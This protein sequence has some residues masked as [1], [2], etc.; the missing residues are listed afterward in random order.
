ML[1]ATVRFLLIATFT[2]SQTDFE[3]GGLPLIRDV[4]VHMLDEDASFETSELFTESGRGA[5]LAN[6]PNVLR[7]LGT[8]YATLPYLQVFE[9]TEHGDLRTFLQDR[10]GTDESIAGQGCKVSQEDYLCRIYLFSDQMHLFHEEG[11]PLRFCQQ[12]TSG[13]SRLHQID[14][15]P[16]DMA[17]RCCQVT[18]DHNIKVGS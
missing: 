2:F 14:A 10:R 16:K 7:I 11:L 17:A 4:M 3:A 9:I 8:N 1:D 13:M 18:H 12:I 15:I 5:E 6:H